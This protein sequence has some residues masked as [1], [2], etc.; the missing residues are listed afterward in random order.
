MKTPAFSPEAPDAAERLPLRFPRTEQEPPR[1]QR[2]PGNTCCVLRAGSQGAGK[3]HSLTTKP[4]SGER[5][6]HTLAELDRVH[7]RLTLKPRT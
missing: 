1:E 7:I 6:E 2:K 3:G 4:R 5:S